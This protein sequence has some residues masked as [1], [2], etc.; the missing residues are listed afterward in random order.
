MRPRYNMWYIMQR[1][2]FYGKRD[3]DNRRV[4][5]GAEMEYSVLRIRKM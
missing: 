2:V 5:W 1:P 3:G 4:S